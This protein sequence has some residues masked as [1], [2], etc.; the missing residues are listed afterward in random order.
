MDF[1]DDVSMKGALRLIDYYNRTYA[2]MKAVAM[3]N[4]TRDVNEVWYNMLLDEFTT[5][6]AL[7]AWTR[8]GLKRRGL[9][10]HLKHLCSQTNPSIIKVSLGHYRKIKTNS[11]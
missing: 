11:S 7:D 10:T 3:S 4:E 6:Q 8:V 9:F 5:E 1:V 2:R